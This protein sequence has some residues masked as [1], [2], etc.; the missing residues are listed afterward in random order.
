MPEQEKPE[1]PKKRASSAQLPKL[2]A[3]IDTLRK[4]L[5][6]QQE[7]ERAQDALIIRLD[8]GIAEAQAETV[9]LEARLCE[10]RR[11][12]PPRVAWGALGRV[13][14]AADRQTAQLSRAELDALYNSHRANP[15][16]DPN[17]RLYEEQEE[18]VVT[19]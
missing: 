15:P 5:A 14:D 16:R 19:A 17:V 6:A 1:K 9:R 8:M 18:K 13:L 3:E 4:E 12:V 2:R 11:M 10:L 7:R